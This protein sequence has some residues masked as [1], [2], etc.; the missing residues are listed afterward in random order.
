M[1]GWQSMYAIQLLLEQHMS[2]MV[3]S[4]KGTSI[5]SKT[6]RIIN[7]FN[8]ESPFTCIPVFLPLCNHYTINSDFVN[9][10]R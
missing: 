9:I 6:N 2:R 3:F 7:L 5:L 8:D 4:D 10:I 1:I